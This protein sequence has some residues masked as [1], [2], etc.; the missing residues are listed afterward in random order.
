MYASQNGI[1]IPE[2]G[3]LLYP[4]IALNHLSPF[5]GILFV[6]GLIAAAY[7]SADSALTSLTTSFCVDFLGFEEKERKESEK[8]KIRLVVHLMFSILLLF[9]IVVFYQI[10]DDA[11]IHQIF[12]V[13]SYTYGPLLGLYTFGFFTK[14]RVKDKWVPA[15]CLLSP[16]LT[17]KINANSEAWL[18]GYKFGYELLLMNGI[19][20][21]IGLLLVSRTKQSA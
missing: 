11:V 9:V 21:F 14:L 7:S 8:R 19:L 5:V 17:Y 20:T 2:K 3:D 12:R 15:V 18:G 16:V 6:L 10:N 4:T 1:A 13:A